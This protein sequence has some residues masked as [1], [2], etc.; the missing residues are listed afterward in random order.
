[1]V[2]PSGNIVIKK[3]TMIKKNLHD[4]NEVYTMEKSKLGSGSYGV[5]HKAIHK[6]SGQERAIKA[7]AKSKIKNM[8]RFRTEVKIM[9]T[10]D[11]PN[12]IKLYEYFE[13]E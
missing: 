5:V 6:A 7:I 4:I 9:Q 10:L 11:H 8:D 1:M 13:D 12:V 2:E 3:E